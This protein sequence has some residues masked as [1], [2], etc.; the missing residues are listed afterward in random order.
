MPENYNTDERLDKLIM[1]GSILVSEL[2]SFLAGI[3]YVLP[4]VAD[5]ET[6]NIFRN[7]IILLSVFSISSSIYLSPGRNDIFHQLLDGQTSF[8]KSQLVGF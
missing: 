6:Q 4:L 1:F 5:E 3:Y 8:S 2:P 7:Y